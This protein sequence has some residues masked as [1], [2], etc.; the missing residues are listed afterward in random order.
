VIEFTQVLIMQEYR[1]NYTLLIGLIIGAFVC[2]GAIWGLHKFQNERQS[3]WLIREADSAR[4]QKNYQD[5]AE[6]LVQYISIQPDDLDA[7]I[8]L[9]NTDLDVLDQDDAA[10]EDI[11]GALQSLETVLR[12]PALATMQETKAARRRLVE[13]YG[14]DNVRQYTPAMD[15]LN[16]LLAD[17]P[18]NP[19]LQVLRA[20]YLAK[21][22]EIDDAVKYSYKLI[23]YDPKKGTFD[24][25]SATAPHAT[26][27]Y[28]SLAGILRSKQSNPTLAEKV[29]NR[30][31]EANPKDALAYVDRGRLFLAWGN[32]EGAKSDAQKAYQLKP[33]DVDVLLLIADVAALDKNLDKARE[34]IAT[35]KKLHPKDSRVYQRSASLEMQDSKLDKALAELDAGAK[36]VGANAATNLLFVKARLQIESGNLKGARQTIEDMQQ[37]R[38][39]P[40]EVNDYFDALIL[41]AESKWYPAVDALSKLR[42]RMA[43]FGKELATEVDFDLALCYERLARWEL[44]KQYYDQIVAQN[45]QNAPAIAGSQRAAAALGQARTASNSKP[46]SGDQLQTVLAEI[47]KKPKDQQDWS[48]VD[49]I[50]DDLAEKNKLPAATVALIKGQ[51][52]MVR[53]DYDAAAKIILA[54]EQKDPSNLQIKRFKIQLARINPKIGPEKALTYWQQVAD[55]FKEEKDQPGLR[56]DKADILVALGKDKQDKQQLKQELETLTTGI[57]NW[58]TP[59]KVELWKGMARLYLNLGMP[60]EARQYLNLVADNQPQ[61]LP[62]RID[63]F[64]MALEAND[65]DGMKAAQDKILQVVGDQ[66]DSAWLWAEARRKLWMMRRGQLG[67][68]ALP[69]VRALIKRALDQR[70]DWS[71]LYAL[72]GEVEL[73]SNNAALA[74][75]NY[76]RAEELGRLA[77][78]VLAAHIKLLCLNG[79]YEDA[80][81]LLDRIPEFARQPLLGPLYTEIL[82]RTNQVEAAIK[83]AKTATEVDPKN[84]QNHYWYS[85]LLARSAQDPKLPEAQRKETLVQATQSMQKATQLQPEFPEAWFALINYLLMQERENDAQKAMRDA[86]LALSGDNLALFLAKGYEA[87]RRWFDA[88]TLYREIYETNPSDLQR[89]QQLAAFYMGPMYP[90]PDRNQKATPLINQLLKAGAEGKLP[91]NDSS[92]LWARRTAA[93]ILAATRDYQSTVKAE[94]LLASN[95]QDGSLLT[96][97]KLA[98]AEI[99]AKRPEPI[100]RKKAIGLLEETD[101]VQP[102]NENA[103]LQL[104]ELYYATGSDWSKYQSEMGK[105][106][107]RYPNSVAAHEAYIRKLLNRGDAASIERATALVTELRKLAPNYPATFELTVRIADKKGLQKQVADELRRRMPNLD[108]TKDDPAAKQTAAMFANLLVDLKDYD[109]AEKIY[110]V[111]AANDPKLVFE[112]AKFLGLHRSIDDCFAKLNEVYAPDRVAQVIEAALGVCRER[113]DKVGDKYDGQIQKWI[114]A[115]LRENPDSLTL[116]TFQADFY[117]LQKKYDEAAGLYRKMLGRKDL[118]GLRRAVVINNLAYLLALNHDKSKTSDVDMLKLISEAV[119][120]LGPNSDILDTRA[121]VYMSAG[122]YKK[123]IADLEL[124]VTDSPTPS[125]YYHLAVAHLKAKESRAAVEAWEK[126]EGM[127]LSRE[128]LNRMEYDQYDQIKTEIDKLRGRSVTKSEPLRKAG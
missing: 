2:T 63:L 94:K 97:D 60:D 116:L 85:Q 117:D 43:G 61:E 82:F 22:G 93:K 13:F 38:K 30:M 124:A 12:N 44:A 41:V 58:A 119:D 128:S 110:R 88:E 15:H 84:A 109:S 24:A 102:L 75:K 79:Q 47:L 29:A 6:F 89:A 25:K 8:K 3:G 34:Y 35:A 73:M 27:V 111:L 10:P 98:M 17:D 68:E 46:G 72:L 5:A 50:I 45:P 120:I 31:V 53:Q 57:D 83:Q 74:L 80:G 42:P 99:L 37:G 59:Q 71:E 77:A 14:R 78:G 92:L 11:A 21:S 49:K 1:I 105:V 114:D 9:A 106:L 52:A 87:L 7:K 55:Q 81:K 16:L 108:G 95:S 40:A 115:G 96:E 64:S 26:D 112:Y 123:A 126:A 54:A 104:A 32:T 28:F 39:L 4:D 118:T 67:R 48:Q 103:A 76:D 19:D 56:L 65:G 121:V 100:S 66:N 90:R 127:G 86:Q 36:A 91:A 125:K 70:P 62:V 33:E 69:D 51:V 23:G 122:E 20:T 107:A 101:R 18:N 113:R